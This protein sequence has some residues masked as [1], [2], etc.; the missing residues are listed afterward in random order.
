MKILILLIVTN[1]FAFYQLSKVLLPGEWAVRDYFKHHPA[2]TQ[3][4]VNCLV[5]Q[6]VNHAPFNGNNAHSSHETEISMVKVAFGSFCLAVVWWWERALRR[7]SKMKNTLCLL[8]SF[9]CVVGNFTPKGILSENADNTHSVSD[10]SSSPNRPCC[11]ECFSCSLA[12]NHAAKS[13]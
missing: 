2:A 9:S 8:F 12:C 13:I 5:E 11:C 10:L 4:F 7:W 1:A 6:S 3:F